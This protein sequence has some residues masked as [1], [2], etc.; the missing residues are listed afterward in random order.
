MKA[1]SKRLLFVAALALASAS[2]P[3]IV[4]QIWTFEHT[5]PAIPRIRFD[6]RSHAGNHLLAAEI[7]KQEA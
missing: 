3:D 6:G 7:A 5:L 4:P 2:T 1:T